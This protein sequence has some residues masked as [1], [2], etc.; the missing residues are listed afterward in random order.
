MRT[1]TSAPILAIATVAL[2]ATVCAACA[3][4]PAMRSP[5]RERLEGADL[6]T[7]ED[8]TRACLTSQGWIPDPVDSVSGGVNV[9]SAHT[10]EREQT[11][12]F[13]NGADQKPRITGGPD[14]DKFWKCL[15][16]TLSGGGADQSSGDGGTDKGGKD[17]DDKGD[18]DPGDKGGG[19][20]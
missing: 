11:Q 10:K 13:I 1:M 9:I 5:L 8:A 2:T 15:A 20:S 17:K 19:A 6:P 16:S 4:A 12:V 18:K 7:I 3:T 14:D